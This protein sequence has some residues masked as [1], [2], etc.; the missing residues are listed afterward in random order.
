V[1]GVELEH[2]Q[3]IGA[4]LPAGANPAD[5]TI[6][7]LSIVFDEGTSAAGIPL[8]PG[9]VYLDNVKVNDQVWTSPADNGGA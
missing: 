7:G 8:G 1:P 5:F 6:S 3:R 4:A 9:Y 2:E